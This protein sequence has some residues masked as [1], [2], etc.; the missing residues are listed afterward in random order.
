MKARKYTLLIVEDDEDQ[1]F[2]F[3]RAFEKLGTKYKIQLASNGNEALAYL[4]GEGKFADRTQFEFPS[5]ILTDLKMSPGDGFHILEF[6]KNT[7]ALSVIPVVMLSTSDDDDDIRQAY[8][9]GASSYFVKPP[10]PEDL[11]AL[12]KKIHDYWSECEV[13]QV[14]AEGYATATDSTGRLGARYTKPTRKASG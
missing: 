1:Q 11:K 14:D 6:L 7:P 8:L 10:D 12:L 4:R 13:P 2:L 5:Y 3:K 9:L